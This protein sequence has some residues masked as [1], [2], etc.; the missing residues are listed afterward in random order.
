MRSHDVS[1]GMEY[2]RRWREARDAAARELRHVHR[3][4]VILRQAQVDAP[5]LQRVELIRTDVRNNLDNNGF[6]ARVTASNAVLLA[7]QFRSYRRAC[8]SP[9]LRCAYAHYST[10]A[11]Q[12]ARILTRETRHVD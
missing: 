4:R 11:I 5:I 8:V 7:R 9:D 6:S 2:L 12:A 1:A 3:A 10:A